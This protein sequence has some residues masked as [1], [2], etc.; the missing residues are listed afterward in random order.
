MPRAYWF[1]SARGTTAVAKLASEAA[2]RRAVPF[3]DPIESEAAALI[4][5]ARAGD[6]EAAQ[7]ARGLFE[8]PDLGP[9]P[10]ALYFRAYRA[11]K[12]AR[13][14]E[15]RRAE[16]EARESTERAAR[17]AATEERRRNRPPAPT[18]NAEYQR[19]WQARQQ[20]AIEARRQL[21]RET[22]A[23]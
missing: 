21:P 5:A 20:A 15:Q 6:A 19:R 3:E 1:N 9:S 12:G 4:R 17:A 11:R 8:L 13:S 22:D 23:E 2:K 16:R 10:T 18:R 7:R 14:R